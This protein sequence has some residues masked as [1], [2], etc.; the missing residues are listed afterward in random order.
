VV[1][2]PLEEDFSAQEQNLQLPSDPR[3]DKQKYIKD[4]NVVKSIEF[5]HPT[6]QIC[7]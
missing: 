1:L 6:A 2:D 3:G 5:F 7:F 4:S